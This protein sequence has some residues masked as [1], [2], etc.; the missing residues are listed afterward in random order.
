MPSGMLSISDC[1]KCSFRFISSKFWFRFCSIWLK[2]CAKLLS[3]S[4]KR[5]A[6]SVGTREDKS[7]AETLS[8][9][10][11][12]RP[13]GA[14]SQRRMRLPK[15]TIKIAMISKLI[16]MIFGAGIFRRLRIIK[17]RILYKTLTVKAGC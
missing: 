11:E 4:R 8:L 12:R 3:S 9:T 6:V 5:G 7:P 1:K 15:A 14:R 13:M 2:V 16:P 10:R 17:I